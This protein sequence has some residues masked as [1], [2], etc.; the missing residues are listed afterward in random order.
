MPSLPVMLS[1]WARAWVSIPEDT[2]LEC[3][4]EASA[5]GDWELFSIR[6]NFPNQTKELNEILQCYRS[7]RI[8]QSSVL[9]W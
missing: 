2:T 7:G 6:Y 1:V 5:R 8:G 4:S 9:S 3:L